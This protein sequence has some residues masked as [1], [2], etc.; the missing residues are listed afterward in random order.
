VVVDIPS[1]AVERLDRP[2]LTPSEPEQ[3]ACEVGVR[4]IEAVLTPPCEDDTLSPVVEDQAVPFRRDGER[5]LVRAGSGRAGAG[6]AR[7][8]DAARSSWTA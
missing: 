7:C 4:Y 6:K 8:S 1:G 3:E 2:V 5:A